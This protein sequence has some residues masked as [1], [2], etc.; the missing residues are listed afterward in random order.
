MESETKRLLARRAK[1]NQVIIRH[2]VNPICQTSSEFQA[3]FGRGGRKQ[4]P[5]T[6]RIMLIELAGV[7]KSAYPH[8]F[9]L[10]EQAIAVLIRKRKSCTKP[11]EK[12]K[13]INMPHV[14][15]IAHID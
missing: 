15:V 12:R 3:Q 11:P 8:Q 13:E 5:L 10:I 6:A 4:R 9:P 7:G 2:G 1:G 14:K